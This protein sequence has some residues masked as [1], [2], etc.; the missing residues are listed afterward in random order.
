MST[1]V[2][3]LTPP[4]PPRKAMQYSPASWLFLVKF[5]HHHKFYKKFKQYQYLWKEYGRTTLMRASQLF[6]Q[7]VLLL[8]EG[9]SANVVYTHSNGETFAISQ[10]SKF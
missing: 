7:I 4:P 9:A 10:C 2:P 8:A 5:D 1:V 3:Y 6:V